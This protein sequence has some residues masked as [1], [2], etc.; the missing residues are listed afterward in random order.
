MVQMVYSGG[1]VVNCGCR[2][3][4]YDIFGVRQAEFVFAL[5]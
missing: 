1:W 2:V 3:S 4:D 5:Y